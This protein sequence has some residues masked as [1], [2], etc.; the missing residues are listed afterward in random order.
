VRFVGVDGDIPVYE[1]VFSLARKVSM[2]VECDG[3]KTLKGIMVLM[4]M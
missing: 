1:C 4:L 3:T 2:L